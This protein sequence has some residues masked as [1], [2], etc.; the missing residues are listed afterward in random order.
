MV[1]MKEVRMERNRPTAKHRDIANQIQELGVGKWKVTVELDSWRPYPK[2]EG[3]VVIWVKGK[4]I[5]FYRD[6]K[7]TEPKIY[8][9][10]REVK[11]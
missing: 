8:Q 9:P 6:E 3:M 4:R 7:A 2:Q 5:L 11:L 10:G 1:P